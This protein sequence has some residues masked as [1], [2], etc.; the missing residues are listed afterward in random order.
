MSNRSRRR[1][2]LTAAGLAAGGA[3]AVAGAVKLVARQQRGHADPSASHDLTPKF[4]R[5]H[6]IDTFDGGTMYVV[7]AGPADGRPVVLA[8]GVT[9]SV[10]TW[11]Y[12]LI[13]LAELGLRVIA[14]DSRGHGQ[15]VCGDAGHELAH[16]GADLRTLI[17]T[18]DLHDAIVVGHSMGGM[19]TQHFATAYPD[20]VRERVSGLVLLSTFAR[21]LIRR[22]RPLSPR[23]QRVSRVGSRVFDLMM[24]RPDA[25]FLMTRTAL[26]RKAP[27]SMVELTRQMLLECPSDTRLLA[28]T[29]IATMD[30][31]RA[32]EAIEGPV[33]VICGTADLLTPPAE[34]RRIARHIAHAEVEWVPGGGHMLMLEHPERI[35]E[36]ISGFAAQVPPHRPPVP[37]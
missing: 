34:S 17:E 36:L 18:L 13:G 9:L 24:E 33:L 11:I 8:H 37:A 30:T 27:P 32:I 21:S 5:E 26:G 15:S 28:S 31:T 10:R 29:A 6:R 35:N 3:L 23:A 25:G 12:Q 22:S 16:L 14:Y 19:A 7:E 20:V 4:E 1:R 2:G